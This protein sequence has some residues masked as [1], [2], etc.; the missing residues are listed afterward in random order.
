M[1]KIIIHL[2]L[3]YSIISCGYAQQPNVAGYWKSAQFHEHTGNIPAAV[4]YYNE[5]L[6][7]QPE[8]SISFYYHYANL[9]KT[10][11]QYHTAILYFEKVCSSESISCMPQVWI[12]LA[13]S[14]KNIAD[15]NHAIH[16]LEQYLQYHTSDK[17]LNERCKKEL[18][19]LQHIHEHINDSAWINVEKAS[20]KI[21]GEYSEYNAIQDDEYGIYF[22]SIRPQSTSNY[23]NLLDDYFISK[24]YLAPYS[25]RGLGE[26]YSLSKH[27][28]NEKYHTGDFCFDTDKKRLFFCRKR[29]SESK[30][31]PWSIWMS[32][33]N[34][35]G[36]WSKPE[37]LNSIVNA[38]NSSNCSPHLVETPDFDILY[39]VSDRQGG[40]GGNDIWYTTFTDKGFSPAVNIGPTI[41]TGG[42]EGSPYYNN[43]QHRL[44]FHSD[45]H[46]GYGGSDIFYAEGE[47]SSWTTPVNM[48]YP[49]N[50]P[51][52][53]SHI[54]FNNDDSS[55]YFATNRKGSLLQSEENCCK[56]IYCFDIKP[57]T[58]IQHYDTIWAITLRQL[59]DTI[60]QLLPISLYFHN[61]EPD[62]KTTATTTSLDYLTTL[63]QYKNKLELYR[64]EYSKGL[65]DKEK[66]QAIDDINHFF[67]N[68]VDYGMMLLDQIKQWLLVDLQCGNNV[69]LTVKGFASPLFSDTYN[70]NLSLRRI[71][72]FKNYIA[73]QPEFAPYL[74]T[75]THS[76]HLYFIDEP[77]GKSMAQK[78]VSNNPNDKRNSIYSI[79]AAMERRIQIEKYESSPS[80]YSQEASILLPAANNIVVK[81]IKNV[82]IYHY[83]F[84]LK[85][86]GEK[87]LNIDDTECDIDGIKIEMSQSEIP[88]QEHTFM[89]IIC[90]SRTLNEHPNG[91]ISI[92]SNNKTI[93]I[94]VLYF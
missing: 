91:K 44:Y 14:Q 3:L 31:Y 32:T 53:E 13:M 71:V 20:T 48:G 49:I 6:K 2:F 67:T 55:G 17:A 52:N 93:H 34:D 74:D 68:K 51:A 27:I 73:L 38:G 92:H 4:Y 85:N 54:K 70:T 39:F 23:N 58:L 77:K 72:S 59:K 89:H 94:N 8:Q 88:A 25:S 65:K 46:V 35:N 84:E 69:Y 45:Y 37:K 76:N 24:I 19:F 79:A 60:Q 30:N 62:P 86:I 80:S 83:Y 10:I 57:D 81:K 11:N 63:T 22:S 18:N 7:H 1:N 9:C 66:S 12:D 47:F 5:I 56:D 75:N 42:D 41:N 50:S 16:S 90:P 26:S 21:N 29:I 64:Y 61:D 36:E 28:N 43:K 40:F 33:L 78:Y 82:D 15:Y 87:T